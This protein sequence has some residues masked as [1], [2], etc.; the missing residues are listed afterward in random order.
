MSMYDRG[1]PYEVSVKA[2]EEVYI[3]Q[4]G[5][6]GTPPFCDG[7]HKSLPGDQSPYL[8]HAEQDTTAW[9]C[10]CGKSGNMP[11]CDGSHNG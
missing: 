3:C 11:F 6:T 9:I 4:C 1:G 7:A 8:Y 10:G 5:A 2:G